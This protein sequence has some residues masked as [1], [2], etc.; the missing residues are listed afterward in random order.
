MLTT[1]AQFGTG[2][3]G[4]ITITDT[5][6]ASSGWEASAQTTDFIGPIGVR[7]TIDGNGL[8]FADV[9]PSYIS[10]NNLAAGSV[11]TNSIDHFRSAKKTFATTTAGPGTVDISGLLQLLAPTSTLPGDYT[12]TITFTVV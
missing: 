9:T 5:R 1:S 11:H 12:A 6:P 4:G 7:T 3:G 10:G 2:A 8:S